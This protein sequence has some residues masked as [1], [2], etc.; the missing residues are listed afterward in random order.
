MNL[1]RMILYLVL[2]VKNADYG[3]AIIIACGAELK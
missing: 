1:F 2:V 3:Y